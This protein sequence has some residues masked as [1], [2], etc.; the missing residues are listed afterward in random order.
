MKQCPRCG[1]QYTDDIS[2][3]LEDGSYLPATQD[4]PDFLLDTQQT[5]FSS[6]PQTQPGSL[7]PDTLKKKNN[8]PLIIG[9]LIIGLLLVVAFAGGI[10]LL[11]VSSKSGS[12]NTNQSVQA[13]LT[14]GNQKS[15]NSSNKSSQIT[16][17]TNSKLSSGNRSER[18]D[19]ENE[20]AN[21]DSESSKVKERGEGDDKIREDKK[22]SAADSDNEAEKSDAEDT[23]LPSTKR[24]EKKTSDQDRE[25]GPLSGVYYG[26][27]LN[28]VGMNMGLTLRINQRGSVIGGKVTVAKPYVGSGP[29]VSGYTDGINISFTSYNRQYQITIN[30]QGRISGNSISG[31]FTASSPSPYVYPN[32]SYGYW[33]TRRR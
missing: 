27:M 30:W 23:K 21:S 32:P 22:G 20:A 9:G 7:A 11:F 13:G 28:Q 24:E 4:K 12:S 8:L 17:T 5:L 6:A 3:C 1:R 10:L 25:T 26:S 29:I 33:Q 15:D 2:F 14:N 19:S 18:N 16:D 31:E